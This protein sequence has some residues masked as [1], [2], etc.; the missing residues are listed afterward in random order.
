[1]EEPEAPEVPPKFRE[2]EQYL[3][4]GESIVASEHY[5]VVVLAK[6]ILIGLGATV[7]AL[8]LDAN[9]PGTAGQAV[10]VMWFTW[11]AV[12]GYVVFQFIEWRRDWFIA[13][14]KRLLLFYGIPRKVAMMPLIK[15]T[16]MTYDRT[17]PGVLL[18]YGRFIME[19][20]GQDQ[21]L[22][23]INFVPRPIH[24]YQV[25]CSEIFGYEIP[26][27]EPEEPP[28]NHP[29]GGT[30]SGPRGW[31]PPWPP[32]RG[33]GGTWD[34]DAPHELPRRSRTPESPQSIYSSPDL[35]RRRRSADTGPIPIHDRR[36]DD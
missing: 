20:A 35:V 13:T 21:A 6:P 36:R 10:R 25:I 24:N 34:V 26:V 22:S 30:P 19:S 31:R 8:W 33:G 15:V 5:H 2:L 32:G 17:V 14:N 16:D 9:L 23:E 29:E 1:M 12:M 4:R 11:L 27:E 7:L 3:I 18:G 28:G